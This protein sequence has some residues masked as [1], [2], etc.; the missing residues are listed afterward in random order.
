MPN[1][2]N[3]DEM[4]LD[5]SPDSSFSGLI[6]TLRRRRVVILGALC[7][8]LAI[9]IALSFLPRKYVAK[10]EIRV[11][12]G[13]ASEFTMD[14]LSLMGDDYDDKIA[15]EVL[16][17]QSRTLYLQVARELNLINDPLFWHSKYHN[18]DDPK[19]REEL[20]RAM[21]SR[22]KI[23]HSSKNEIRPVFG[24]GGGNAIRG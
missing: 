24:V 11:Q 12:P 19:D 3:I 8:F 22:I 1:N 21:K 15:S 18:I 20:Y 5:E 2:P 14:P 4:L 7:F 9:G 6:D 17:L 10:G 23:I 16:I 13:Q